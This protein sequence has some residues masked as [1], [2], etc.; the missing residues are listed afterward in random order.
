MACAGGPGRTPNGL[1]HSLAQLQVGHV[2]GDVIKPRKQVPRIHQGG[3]RRGSERRRRSEP[4]LLPEA[5][6][7]PIRGLLK[8]DRYGGLASGGRTRTSGNLECNVL[9]LL[10]HLGTQIPPIELTQKRLCEGHGA[11]VAMQKSLVH[12]SIIIATL[13]Q[14]FPRSI[15]FTS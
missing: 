8:G 15:P 1:P 2:L 4:F 9:A 14:R 5:D 12:I 11:Q 10:K 13:A 7:Y 3:D 6:Q